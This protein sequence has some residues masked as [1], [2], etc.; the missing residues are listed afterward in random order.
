M[1]GT[2][3]VQVVKPG[4]TYVGAHRGSPMAQERRQ[5][6]LGAQKICMNVMP[7][8][9]GA[10]A[11]VHYHDKIETIAY[12]LEGTCR[13]YYGDQARG[14]CRTGRRR[15]DLHPRRRGACALQSLWCAVYLD[16][17]AFVRQ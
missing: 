3:G 2:E 15:A 1:A 11:K 10:Q 8:P 12:L 13:V 5:R 14:M 7:M 6:L 9:N 16:R 17:R 4:G